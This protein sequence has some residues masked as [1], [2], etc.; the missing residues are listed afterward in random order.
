MENIKYPSDFLL[1]VANI[2][3]KDGNPIPLDAIRIDFKF[4]GEGTEVYEA[5]WDGF[6]SGNNKN[7]YSEYDETLGRD[8]LFVIFEDYKIYG[9][10][11]MKIDTS[12]ENDKFK[13]NRWNLFGCYKNANI[14]ISKCDI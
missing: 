4:K 1:R 2:T 10:I 13:D 11:K 14:K 12:V 5:T 8:V 7:T 3:D 9:D 6:D